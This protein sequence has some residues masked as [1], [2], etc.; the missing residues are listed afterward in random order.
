MRA[1]RTRET[2][3]GRP[4]GKENAP[5]IAPG[6]VC[7]RRCASS[8]TPR[9][10]SAQRPLREAATG[11]PKPDFQRLPGK[12]DPASVMRASR[13]PRTFSISSWLNLYDMAKTKMQVRD[14]PSGKMQR[15]PASRTSPSSSL[16]SCPPRFAGRAPRAH[17]SRRT[18]RRPGS[19]SCARRA[20]RESARRARW[21]TRSMPAHVT[22]ARLCFAPVLA[23]MAQFRQHY[24][25]H[26]RLSFRMRS[27]TALEAKYSGRRSRWP[28]RWRGGSRGRHMPGGRW[29]RTRLSREI[30]ARK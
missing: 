12:T 19:V 20:L 3:S 24:R 11:G 2:E 25:M 30:L 22:R 16:P 26:R 28:A 15:H 23:G 4:R 29:A 8:W 9:S 13:N 17:C 6:I 5:R 18:L 1:S 10:A 27:W 14:H 7:T 21:K